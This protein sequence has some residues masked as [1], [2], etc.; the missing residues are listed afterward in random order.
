MQR[1]YGR[2]TESEQNKAMMVSVRRSARMGEDGPGTNSNYF[3]SGS[4]KSSLAQDQGQSAREGPLHSNAN[5]DAAT[6]GSDLGPMA[7]KP[8]DRRVFSSHIDD[9]ESI[10]KS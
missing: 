5:S 2:M 1:D 3:K 7:V 4:R 9:D 10:H 6:T 8:D